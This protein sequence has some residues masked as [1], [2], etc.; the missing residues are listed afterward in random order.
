MM[1]QGAAAGGSDEE[2]YENIKAARGK[3]RA[4]LFYV[5]RQ[6]PA[7]FM[8]ESSRAGEGEYFRGRAIVGEAPRDGKMASVGVQS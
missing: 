4:A 8:S 1:P 5:L 3:T 7:G 2:C 6:G